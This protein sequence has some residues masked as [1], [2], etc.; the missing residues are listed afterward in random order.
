[1]RISLSL[2]LAAFVDDPGETLNATQNNL[3]WMV[4]A[5][6]S[7]KVENVLPAHETA[8]TGSGMGLFALVVPR[9][10]MLCC[11]APASEGRRCGIRRALPSHGITLGFLSCDLQVRNAA[12]PRS[13]LFQP[14]A[15]LSLN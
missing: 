2:C 10:V 9:V 11:G 6:G 13:A 12:L 3:K 1:M 4:T 14:P 8:G 15:P 5:N 7:L